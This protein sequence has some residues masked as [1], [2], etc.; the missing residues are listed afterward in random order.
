M[1]ATIRL[2]IGQLKACDSHT[3]S[4]QKRCRLPNFTSDTL[5][6]KDNSLFLKVIMTEF[7][8]DSYFFVRFHL[9]RK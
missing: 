6:D 9:Q 5:P 7:M 2:K 8:D 4:A 3:F 1:F